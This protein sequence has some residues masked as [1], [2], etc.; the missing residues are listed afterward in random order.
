M[1]NNLSLVLIATAAF[2]YLFYDQNAGVNFLIFNALLI[3]LALFRNRNLAY[4]RAWIFSALMCVVSSAAIFIN[5]S[6]L[7]VFANICGM[8][9]LSAYSF[10]L[11]S[12][13]IF[14]GFYSIY[15]VLG[16]V[17]HVFLDASKRTI[18]PLAGSQGKRSYRYFTIFMAVLMSLLFFVLYRNSNPLFAENTAWINLKFISLPWFVFTSFGFFISYGLL[19]HK[20]IFLVEGLEQGLLLNTR[21]FEAEKQNNHQ[22]EISSG[23]ILL[24]FLNI[25]LFVLNVGDARTI[26]FED[27]L[28]EGMSHSDFVHDGVQLIIFSI[29]IAVGLIIF[30]SRRDF[31]SIK[32]HNVLKALIY[33]WILQN[34]LML[35]STAYRN[36]IYIGIFDLT[37]LRIGVYVWLFLAV[38]GLCFTFLMV[39]NNKS[40]WYLIR[41]N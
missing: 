37:Y 7:A 12:S 3:F 4:K 16:S 38:L 34:V 31:R 15:S 6:A 18:S 24:V 30:L 40:A 32:N 21:N 36:T 35:L 41:A 1:K 9:L 33:I 28:P 22:T 11:E 20:T 17:I 2:S 13:P 10:R 27:G 26:F 14:A 25:M 5:S 39:K 23:I 8:L 29:V 19:N